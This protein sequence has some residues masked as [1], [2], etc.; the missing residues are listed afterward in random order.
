MNYLEIVL[1]NVKKQYLDQVIGGYIKYNVSDIIS[2]HF[3]DNKK[4]RDMEYSD[5]ENFESYF[6][7]SGT[8]SIYLKKIQIGMELNEVLILVG[9]DGGI[10]DITL[11]FMEEQFEQKEKRELKSNFRKLIQKLAELCECCEADKILFGY[12]PAEDDD[13]KIMEIRQKQIMNFNEDIHRSEG[14]QMLYQTVNE[15]F[16]GRIIGLR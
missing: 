9:C 1:K 10:A 7:E 2:S 11:S 14:M 4:Q 16:G 15:N 8:C 3:Y 13:M 12:E 6:K 5:I